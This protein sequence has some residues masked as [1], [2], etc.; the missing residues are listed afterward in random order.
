MEQPK[1]TPG[2]WSADWDDN[3]QWY[4][5]VGGLSVSGNALRGDNGE[6]VESA[7]AQLIA[8]AP[9]LFDTL[10]ALV[11]QIDLGKAVDD[12]G[13]ELKNLKALNDAKIII[14][15]IEGR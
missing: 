7:N 3:G 15:R 13:H 4:I 10:K 5:N 2:P 6:C 9:D 12:H 8:A 11:H 14:A 1:H